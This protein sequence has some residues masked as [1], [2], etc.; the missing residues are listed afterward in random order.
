[1]PRGIWH[2]DP[3]EVYWATY[4][5]WEDKT[6]GNTFIVNDDTHESWGDMRTKMLPV[7]PMAGRNRTGFYLHGGDI[8]GSEGCLDIGHEDSNVGKLI[9]RQK[10]TISLKVI[11]H[12]I[13]IQVPGTPAKKIKW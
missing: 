1:M 12:K 8:I 3:H 9:E 5:I 7:F 10:Q 4:S 13:P 6:K 11:Y 2:I